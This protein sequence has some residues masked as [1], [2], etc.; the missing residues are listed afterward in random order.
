MIGPI[1]N[2]FI[3]NF[4]V[5]ITCF[6]AGKIFNDKLKIKEEFSISLICGV[7]A[8]SQISLIL[9]FFTP[10]NSLVTYPLI[11]LSICY[12]I[13]QKKLK[14][15]LLKITIISFFSIF[16]YFK[17]NHAEDFTIYHHI[18]LQA[19]ND[20]KII[21]GLTHLKLNLGQSPISFYGDAIFQNL[22]FIKHKINYLSYILFCSLIIFLYEKLKKKE[23]FEF[24]EYFLIISSVYFLIKFSRLG[25]HGADFICVA[26]IIIGL[27]FFLKINFDEVKNSNN[28]QYIVLSSILIS[29]AYFYKVFA[30]SFYI[31]LIAILYLILKNKLLRKYYL[32]ITLIVILNLI[33]LLKNFLISG[34]LIFPI[35]HTCFDNLSWGI[36]TLKIHEWKTI[37]EAWT[38]GWYNYFT[39]EYQ[40]YILNFNWLDTWLN[41][42]FIKSLEKF[43]VPIFLIITLIKLIRKELIY[44]N[45][46]KINIILIFF[47]SLISVLIWFFNSPLLRLG[48]IALIPFLVILLNFNLFKNFN[49]KINKKN[50]FILLIFFPIFFIVKNTYRIIK[51]SPNYE[52]YPY[53]RINKDNKITVIK[54]KIITK[55]ENG[56]F[57]KVYD[58][59]KCFNIKFPCILKNKEKNK[60]FTFNNINNYL[61]LK[62]L[63]EQN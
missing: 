39:I 56:V 46:Y 32:L 36:G 3:T 19:I 62:N 44:D 53:P 42:H 30:I 63:N 52:E 50:I 6:S 9:N 27:Y 24:S 48:L 38:K 20:Y 22:P 43:F 55:K 21:L 10:I 5:I 8:L 31:L 15:K 47:T 26:I 18:N 40:K 1:F 33:F 35:P 58:G 60:N 29:N 57:F 25:T 61:M 59:E 12:F 17:G 34:C 51:A 49:F 13:L 16:F 7:L 45:K 23:Y 2:I 4:I 14:T 54:E 41:N 28:H 11:F 37:N